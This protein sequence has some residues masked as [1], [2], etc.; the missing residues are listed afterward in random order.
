MSTSAAAKFVGGASEVAHYYGFRPLPEI[1]PE[2]AGAKL[3][4]LAPQDAAAACASTLSDGEPA[5]A[6]WASAGPADTGPAREYGSF[7]LQIVGCPTSIGEVHILKTLEAIVTEAGAGSVS[8]ALNCLGDKDSRVRFSRELAAYLRRNAALYE[9]G[10]SPVECASIVENPTAAYRISNEALQ[11]LLQDGPRPMHFLSEKSRLHFRQVL[12]HLERVN[13]PFEIDNTLAG[14]EYAAGSGEPRVVFR[15]Q[16]PADAGTITGSF[17]G[18]FDD[19]VRGRAAVPTLHA[20][21]FFRV[22][23]PTRDLPS[24]TPTLRPKVYLIQFGDSARLTGFSVLESL[25]RARVPVAAQFDTRHLAPQL[26][27]AER[28][29]VPYVLIMGHREALDRTVII[30]AVATSSQQTVSIAELPKHLRAL[31]LV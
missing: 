18:R 12:E 24:H 28:I 6:F 5:L 26:M 25:R 19:L 9:A 7:S 17:G 30:R 16:L 14:S 10:L 27:N 31:K 11:V 1:A 20:S 29:G 2:F 21:V 15:L 8:V 23:A 3:R 22:K 4:S 13:I